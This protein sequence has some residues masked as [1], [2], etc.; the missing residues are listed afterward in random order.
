[1][2]YTKETKA[3]L[4]IW[5]I[6]LN[7]PTAASSLL[8][9]QTHSSSLPPQK[10]LMKTGGVIWGGGLKHLSSLLSG[11]LQSFAWKGDWNWRM[12]SQPLWDNGFRADPKVSRSQSIPPCRESPG[13]CSSVMLSMHPVPGTSGPECSDGAACHCC[14]SLIT[15]PCGLEPV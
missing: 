2:Q 14:E 11:L 12:L 6:Q 15:C 1:M 4:P 8:K 3:T 10:L 5:S 7:G 13:C 9:A